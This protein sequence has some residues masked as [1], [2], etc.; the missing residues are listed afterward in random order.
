[1]AD[2][3][4]SLADGLCLR[5]LTETDHDFWQTLDAGVLAVRALLD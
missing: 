5:M 3:L 2:V 1:V 4:F